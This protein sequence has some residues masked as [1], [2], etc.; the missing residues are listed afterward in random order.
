VSAIVLRHG[1]RR[2]RIRCI[3]KY[4]EPAMLDP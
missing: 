1:G 3:K 2:D 4:V